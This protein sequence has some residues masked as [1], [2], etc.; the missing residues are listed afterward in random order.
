MG[1]HSNLCITVSIPTANSQQIIFI[2]HRPP[3]VLVQDS[4]CSL[5][6]WMIQY[7]FHQQ[8]YNHKLFLWK[9]KDLVKL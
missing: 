2:V 8:D 4:N 3:G 7:I 1:T 9:K 5:A 6:I